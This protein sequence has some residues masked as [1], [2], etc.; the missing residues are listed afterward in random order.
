[1]MTLVV[2][3]LR[4]SARTPLQEGWRSFDVAAGLRACRIGRIE[5]LGNKNQQA[6]GH[7]RVFRIPKFTERPNRQ[8]QRPAAT[9]TNE[10]PRWA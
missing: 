4:A 10:I 8:A 7:R 9:P 6:S 1:M 3:A 2:S 5:G